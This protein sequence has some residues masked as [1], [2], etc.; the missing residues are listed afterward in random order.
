MD[1]DAVFQQHFYIDLAFSSWNNLI[2]TWDA[3][4]WAVST[5]LNK[6]EN[7]DGPTETNHRRTAA[8]DGGPSSADASLDCADHQ[9]H[10]NLMWWGLAFD[11]GS[12]WSMPLQFLEVGFHVEIHAIEWHDFERDTQFHGVV[13]ARIEFS[14]FFTPCPWAPAYWTWGSSTRGLA[15]HREPSPSE[16]TLDLVML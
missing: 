8:D 14:L 2:G 7:G 1:A 16:L 5:I 11:Y 15:A 13:V 3:N 6:S 12:F 4:I 9:V 10:C